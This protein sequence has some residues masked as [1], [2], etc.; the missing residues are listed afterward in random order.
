MKFNSVNVPL[1][2]QSA[3]DRLYLYLHSHDG[4]L[5]VVSILL[6]RYWHFN[7]SCAAKIRRLYDIANILASLNLIC[8]VHVTELRGRKP[9][10]SYIGPDVEELATQDGKSSVIVGMYTLYSMSVSGGRYTLNE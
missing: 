7:I 4:I 10:F 8:K 3:S 2:C 6:R 5:L 9:A 1:V